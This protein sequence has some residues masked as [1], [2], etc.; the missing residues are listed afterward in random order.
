MQ[1]GSGMPR[2]PVNGQD[3]DCGR[4]M[5][6]LIVVR[7]IDRSPLTVPGCL[8]FSQLSHFMSFSFLSPPKEVS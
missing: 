5:H 8:S 4:F 2:F 6:G 3:A 7:A 1:F